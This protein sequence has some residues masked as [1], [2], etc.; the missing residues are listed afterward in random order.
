VGLIS[1]GDVKQVSPEDYDRL[2]VREV[3]MPMAERLAITPEED[4]SVALQRMAE[5]GLGRLIV[6]A[7]GRMR[8]LVT[9]TGL[10]RFLQM[11]LELHL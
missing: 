9:K 2:S 11:K 3:M 4:V 5:E 6:M 7:R 8:G 10:S 1:L